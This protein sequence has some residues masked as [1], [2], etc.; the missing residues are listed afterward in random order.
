M[1]IWKLELEC[2]SLTEHI[3]PTFYTLLFIL[4]CL[5]DPLFTS[6]LETHFKLASFR[7]SNTHSKIKNNLVINQFLDPI[8]NIRTLDDV[9]WNLLNQKSLLSR[10][11][12]FNLHE[13]SS[14]PSWCHLRIL[15]HLLSILFIVILRCSINILPKWIIVNAL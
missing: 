7:K 13:N 9:W 5:W 12:F 14:F 6:H 4:C 11:S 3:K 10:L 1:I 15:V 2:L 8:N